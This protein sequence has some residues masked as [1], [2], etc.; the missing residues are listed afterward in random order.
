MGVYE[1]EGYTK[2]NRASFMG[3]KKYVIEDKDKKLHITIAGVN[4]KYGGEE[5]GVLENFKEGFIFSKS[6][7]TEAIYN[8]KVD[9]VIKVDGH[10][11][12]VTDNMYIRDSTYTLGITAE[13]KAILDGL[14]DIK[15]SDRDI[16]GLYKV[17]N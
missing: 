14:I 11:I 15:Y 10:N 2:P 3:A 1:D 17:K 8:D 12:R 13:Y 9:F 5:L 6:G 16:P 4:K 7:G